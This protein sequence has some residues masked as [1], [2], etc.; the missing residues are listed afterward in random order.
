[1]ETEIE[2]LVDDLS[3]PDLYTRDPGAFHALSKQLVSRREDLNRAE[4]RWLE[5]GEM[6]AGN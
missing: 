4:L 2:K 6:R 1:M 5:L 3:D